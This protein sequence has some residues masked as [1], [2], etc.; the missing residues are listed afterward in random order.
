MERSR[1]PM[2][3][4]GSGQ[5]PEMV[6]RSFDESMIFQRKKFLRALSGTSN[7]IKEG[8]LLTANHKA[9]KV[10]SFLLLAT[11]RLVASAAC[12]LPERDLANISSPIQCSIR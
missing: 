3:N 10:Y 7:C 12:Y 11:H 8:N 6:M 4:I 2:T 1:Q 5:L 9:L